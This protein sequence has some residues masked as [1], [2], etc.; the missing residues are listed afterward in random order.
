MLNLRVTNMNGQWNKIVKL[1]KTEF[2]VAA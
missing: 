2:K 1:V